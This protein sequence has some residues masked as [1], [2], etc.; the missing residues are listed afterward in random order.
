MFSRI[1]RFQ[2]ALRCTPRTAGAWVDVALRCGYADQSHLIRDF[3][4]FAGET[5]TALA[6]STEAVAGYFRR[7]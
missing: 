5:P 6:A 7:R 4:Q 3:T 2:H 1:V